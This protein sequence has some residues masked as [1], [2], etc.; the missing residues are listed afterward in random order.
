MKTV[1]LARR[2]FTPLEE[3]QDAFVL[4]EDGNISEVGSRSQTPLPSQV[5]SFDFGE[6][7]LTPGFFDIHTHGG[8]GVDAM[9]ASADEFSRLGKFLIQHGVT[10]YFPTTVAAPLDATYIALE[11]LADAIEAAETPGAANGNL[12]EARPLGIHLEGPFLSH[13]R[14]GVHPPEYLVEPTLK[15]FDELWHAARGP[16]RMMTIAP[17]IPGAI[18]VIAEAA[19]R[20]VC[21]RIGRSDPDTPPP[22]QP[23]ATTAPH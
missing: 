8:G 7:V 9:R 10:G 13:K 19:P 14:R 11:R 16:A 12:V 17:E 21:V 1:F 23:L 18:E 22:G 15:I 3:I 2:L 4:V 6:S 20:G 5:K